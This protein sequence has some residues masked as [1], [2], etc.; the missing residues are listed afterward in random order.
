M[1]ALLPNVDPNGLLEYS[2]VYTD[3]SLNH[4]S[5]RFQDVMRD[6]SAT[7]KEVYNADSSVIVPGSGTFGMEAV[8]RQFAQNEKVLI[9]RNGWFSYRWTQIIEMGR[10][11]DDHTALKARRLDPANARSPFAPVPA[12]EVAERIRAEKPAVVFAPQVETSA[13]VL[14]PDDY[15]REVA[16]AAREVGALFVLDAIAAGTLWVDMQD[17][18]VDVVVSAPQKGWSGQP[19]CAM[20]M[21]GSRAVERLENTQSNSF[22]CD[23][24]KWHAIMQAYENG[25]HAYH[26]TMP[27]D[28]LTTLRD[29]MQETREYGLDKVKQEQIDL[30]LEVRAMLARQGFDSVAAEGFQA[31]GVVV[32]YTDDAGIVGKLAG[33]GVQVAGGVPLMCD[34]G[35]DFQ[36]FRI[37]LFG[38]DKLHHTERSVDKLERAIEQV[39]T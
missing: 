7:L 4:M 38:L 5:Q 28:A 19:C 34:E 30:G 16:S 35:D 37:G 1:A 10:L 9:V 22:A 3:R 36:T 13:G 2:V 29:I 26:A 31:P 11:T 24:G 15:I 17:L 18:N 21:L 14:L 27:T 8:A 32:S 20:V 39:K 6:I 33:A 23:L 25:G 12:A